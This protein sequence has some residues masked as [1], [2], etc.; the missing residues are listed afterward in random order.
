M[1]RIIII[2]VRAKRELHGHIGVFAKKKKL[3]NGA[4]K[5]RPPE[6]RRV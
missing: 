6:T 1:V 3:N 2:K 5:T 4:I